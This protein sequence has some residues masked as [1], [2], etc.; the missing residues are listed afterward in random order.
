LALSGA[1]AG[2][3]GDVRATTSSFFSRPRCQVAVRKRR[4]K[5]EVRREKPERI[6]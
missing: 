5:M 6:W 3:W 2:I 4:E 1:V